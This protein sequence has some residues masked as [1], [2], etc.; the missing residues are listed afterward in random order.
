M[1][2]IDMFVLS[3]WNMQ[4]ILDVKI[5]L[6][7]LLVIG[8]WFDKRKIED[9]GFKMNK[10]WF[11]EFLFGCIIG[12]TFVSIIFI[13]AYFSKW[14]TISSFFSNI[15]NMPT[16]GAFIQGLYLLIFQ[17]F[18]L[19]FAYRGYILRNTAEGIEARIGSKHA[20]IF[21]T[22]ISGLFQV[23]YNILFSYFQTRTT[24]SLSW[25][26]SV[27][28]F[29]K[30]V[31]TSVFYIYTGSLSFLVGFDFLYN[32]SMGFIYDFANK[33]FKQYS[34]MI[35]LT[36]SNKSSY[37]KY[38]LGKSKY[39]PEGGFIATA[40]FFLILIVIVFYLKIKSKFMKQDELKLCESLAEFKPTFTSG[41]HYA[42]I[43]NLSLDLG[44]DYDR[45][46]EWKL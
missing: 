29:I 7:L 11:V 32:Y 42:P 2:L 26:G 14:V 45:N 35:C 30:G 5:Q 28:A 36:S 13:I 9:F 31:I 34:C 39:G 4:L 18:L 33:G 22:F 23:S 20:L 46:D 15:T 25:V 12:F 6:F 19:I 37:V 38:L 8:A 44:E 27:N 10:A 40:L 43:S 3:K 41:G 21:A 24:S 16:V 17:S 1:G